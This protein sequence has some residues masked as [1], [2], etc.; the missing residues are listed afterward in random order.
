[1]APAARLARS[2]VLCQSSAP[3]SR[4]YLVNM[5]TRQTKDMV[6]PAQ[7]GFFSPDGKWITFSHRL[8]AEHIELIAAPFRNGEAA[9]DER[10]KLTGG[11]YN[12]NK[13]R[14]SPNGWFLY[15]PSNHDSFICVGLPARRAR[16]GME[17]K[18]LPTGGSCVF[19]GVGDAR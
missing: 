12:D 13:P 10:V 2:A 1:M 18:D 11:T 7:A 15:F 19:E 9:E 4:I 17:T 8:S 16:I 14:L 6:R 3:R 5:A